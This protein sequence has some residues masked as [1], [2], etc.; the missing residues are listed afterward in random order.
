M[1]LTVGGST[2]W[3]MCNESQSL[4]FWG[5]GNLKLLLHK[6]N[7]TQQRALGAMWLI[8]INLTSK[9]DLV[10]AFGSSNIFSIWLQMGSF[11]DYYMSRI[12]HLPFRVKHL[13]FRIKYLPF[14]IK[15]LPFRVKHLPFR[16]KHL[17]FRIKHLP[18][19]V[20]HLPFRVKHLPFGKGK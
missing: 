5:G 8:S 20:K 4:L 11:F 16:I 15:H 3:S 19:R 1:A 9:W 14:R 12:K 17:P 13:P 7:V 10:L 2:Q 18:F 6:E